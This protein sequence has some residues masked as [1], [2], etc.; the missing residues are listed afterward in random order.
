MEDISAQVCEPSKCRCRNNKVMT[1]CA[2][3]RGFLSDNLLQSVDEGF[4]NNSKVSVHQLRIRVVSGESKLLEDGEG[5]TELTSTNE[6]LISSAPPV[7]NK[8]PTT[9]KCVTKDTTNLSTS[10]PASAS[11]PSMLIKTPSTEPSI[12]VKPKSLVDDVSPFAANRMK[13]QMSSTSSQYNRT[14]LGW[15]TINSGEQVWIYIQ[16]V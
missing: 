16:L 11:T 12:T 5:K 2:N 8:A 7:T 1:F 6:K 3:Q 4:L 10:K 15:A 9:I 13:L 14:S